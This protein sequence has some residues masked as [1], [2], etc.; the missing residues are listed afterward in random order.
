MGESKTRPTAKPKA[1]RKA[2]A[3]PKSPAARPRTRKASSEKT[4][5]EGAVL[6]HEAAGNGTRIAPEERHRMIA[7]AAYYRAQRRR[8]PASPEQDWLEAE[9]EIDTLLLNRA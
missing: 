1:A 5:G 2:T 9:M 7:E 8:G 6:G 3:V 4:P